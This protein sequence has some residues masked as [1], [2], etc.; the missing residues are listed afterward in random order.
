M[1]EIDIHPAAG[2]RKIASKVRRKYNESAPGEDADGT[3][4]THLG[5][6]LANRPLRAPKED[7]AEITALKKNLQDA[8]SEVEVG[9]AMAKKQIATLQS[10]WKTTREE[11]EVQKLA[12]SADAARMASMFSDL[13]GQLDF[14]T[15]RAATESG[16]LSKERNLWRGLASSAG[17]ITLALVCV[18]LWWLASLSSAPVSNGRQ[19]G[20]SVLPAP[21]NELPLDAAAEL[22]NALN[23]LDYAL[24]TVPGTTAEAALRKVS[25]P[26]KGCMIIWVDDHPSVVFGR[27][28]L[29][30]NSIANTLSDCV[31]AVSR[32][33]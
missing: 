30:P 27:A 21:A 13:E 31:D 23:S 26:G 25:A 4:S 33:P 20:P 32:L 28:P 12:R 11:L 16:A 6:S 24:A 5:K 3:Y 10:Q 15:T 1:P 14:V 19:S 7:T 9:A 8:A 22:A 2:P 29:R 18:M 17:V